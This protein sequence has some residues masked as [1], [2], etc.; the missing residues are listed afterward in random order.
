MLIK[1][2]PEGGLGLQDLEIKQKALRMSWFKKIVLYP[3][4]EMHWPYIFKNITSIDFKDM[5]YINCKAKTLTA[6]LQLPLLWKD[7]LSEWA[8]LT[9]EY[10]SG[11]SEILS[12][13]LWYN[14]HIQ[15]NKR[16][17]NFRDLRAIGIMQV[18]H[19]FNEDTCKFYTIEE[20]I[21]NYGGN[22]NY[23][24]Y[25]MLKDAIPKDWVNKI[26]EKRN[27]DIIYTAQERLLNNQRFV[28]ACYDKI[29]N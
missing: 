4:K 21:N 19:I 5:L 22:F 28:K 2:K 17:I 18:K 11:K 20:I 13:Y 14:Q 25:I 23:M 3:E 9:Y 24:H 15:C 12:Q 8:D 27:L 10:P 6:Q 26:K 7:I 16:M 1:P 29:R